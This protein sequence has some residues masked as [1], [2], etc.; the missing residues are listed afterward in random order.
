MAV[1][2]RASSSSARSDREGSA[3]SLHVARFV[4]AY[5]RISIATHKHCSACS[6]FARARRALLL[7]LSKRSS[8]LFRGGA[9]IVLLGGLCE[10]LHGGLVNK[11]LMIILYMSLKRNSLWLVREGSVC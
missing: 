11:Y 1:C 2:A 4:Q 5:V 8:P 3:L 7:V 9:S 10:L 6:V